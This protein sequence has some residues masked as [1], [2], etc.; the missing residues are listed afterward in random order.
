[1][2]QWPSV[3]WGGHS[4]S[5]QPRNKIDEV[6]ESK[7]KKRKG[8]ESSSLKVGAHKLSVS[9]ELV[10]GSST[11][12]NAASSS[13]QIPPLVVEYGSRIISKAMGVVDEIVISD[14][15]NTLLFVFA[16]TALFELTESGTTCLF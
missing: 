1:M 15:I 14:G 5:S 7:N 8:I 10:R 12:S 16:S 11:S 2:S 9:K 6:L 3:R 13:S 4:S